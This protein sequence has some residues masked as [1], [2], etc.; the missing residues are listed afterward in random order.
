MKRP[1]LSF[2]GSFSALIAGLLAVLAGGCAPATWESRAQHALRQVAEGGGDALTRVSA[3]ELALLVRG[4]LAR[5]RQLLYS[6]L[7]GADSTAPLRA[8][9]ALALVQWGR[10]TGDPAVV[11]DAVVAGLPG[12]NPVQA[13]ALAASARVVWGNTAAPGGAPQAL[14]D[15]LR[16]VAARP[17]GRWSPARVEAL[18]QLQTLG[19]IAPELDAQ[20]RAFERGGVITTWTLSAP[21]GDSPAF[22]AR[23]RLG[24]EQRPLRSKEQTGVGWSASPRATWALTFSDGELAFPD[25]PRR[26]GVGFAEAWI[27]LPD[28]R[29]DRRVVARL[30]SNRDV[31]L[32]IDATRVIEMDRL[33]RRQ[34][35]Q[36]RAA[37]ELPR[38]PVRVLVKLAGDQPGGFA[39]V[40]ITPWTDG[41]ADAFVRA[42]AG[43]KQSFAG[44]V[45]VIEPPRDYLGAFARP[46][47]VGDSAA[48]IQAL[49]VFDALVARPRRDSDAAYRQLQK[50]AAAVPGFPGLGLAQN[51]LHRVDSALATAQSRGQRRTALEGVLKRWPRNLPSHIAMTQLELAEGRNDEALAS[52]RQALKAG[53]RD[54]SARMLELGFYRK[55]GWEAEAVA[56]ARALEGR[57]AHSPRVLQE[58][59]DTFRSYG[60]AADV[61]RALNALEVAFPQQAVVRR[62]RWHGDRGEFAPRAR[63]LLGHW[64][65]HPQR[66]SLIQRGVR[67]LRSAGKHQEASEAVQRLL[68]LRPADPWALSEAIHLAIDRGD[69]AASRGAL[70]GALKM[71]PD[72]LKLDSLRHWLVG[73]RPPLR[74]VTDSLSL[75]AAYRARTPSADKG[76]ASGGGGG[77]LADYPVVTLLDRTVIDV[78]P[79]GRRRDL[80]HVVRVVQSKSG[81]DKLG[82]LRPPADAQL[83][84]VR[85][86]K[87]DGRVLWPDRV[88]GKPDLSFSGLAPG[89]AVE[90]AWIRY[91]D[92]R[93]EEGGYVTG[94]GFAY[95]SVPTLRKEVD[96]AISPM[97]QLQLHTHNGAPSPK[98]STVTSDSGDPGAARQL[99]RWAVDALPAVPREPLAVSARLFFPYVDLT[100]WPAVSSRTADKRAAA[101]R[102]V[103]KLYAGRLERLTQ[104]GPRATRSA[105]MMRKRAQRGR[106]KSVWAAFDYVKEEINHTERLNTFQLSAEQALAAQKGNRSVAL[107]AVAR[108]LGVATDLVLCAPRPY[109]A[110]VDAAAPL[111][112]ANRFYYPVVRLRQGGEVTYADPSRPYNPFGVLPRS[113]YSARCL[114]L[115]AASEAESTLKTALITLPSY[116][117]YEGTLIGWTFDIAIAVDAKGGGQGVLEGVGF[118]PVAS[119]LRHVYL[120]ADERRRESLWQQWTASVLKGARV[121]DW[122]VDDEIDADKPITWRVEFTIPTFLSQDGASLTKQTLLTNTL[123]HYLGSVAPLEGLARLPSRTTPLALKPHFEEVRLRVRFPKSG[124]AKVTTGLRDHDV[125]TEAFAAH[126]HVTITDSTLPIE[127]DLSVGPGRVAPGKYAAFRKQVLAVVEAFGRGVTYGP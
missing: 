87:R 67:A 79:D 90:W 52:L 86:I 117:L 19:R 57:G 127:R 46:I 10:S 74:D 94:L 7:K 59:L 35:W 17:G 55:R 5:S 100:V 81:A 56:A 125:D 101:W 41:G 39:R 45:T 93:A 30:E 120:N 18:T 38:G 36:K 88:A 73:T 111:P 109:G 2:I 58:V 75:I 49:H 114:D 48:A 122:E 6:V 14:V 44:S 15:A 60:R 20:R 119:G 123:A 23:R 116:D 29:S 34:A 72:L 31:S 112:N 105:A 80:T 71:R 62:A 32:W 26:G 1:C 12:S 110:A 25:M 9:A 3:G 24:P 69:A 54:L 106:M 66:L 28:E 16:S 61:T 97:F 63:L 70:E 99:Y 78:G 95:W 121:V 108:A 92:V 50:V 68:S 8:R 107:V 53:P 113:L 118:G 85:T 47:P 126:Q 4:D 13:E 11:A 40:R 91:S 65:H 64:T 103:A 77:A 33:V 89:D 37:F 115:A 98:V 96:V 43:R 27:E 102:A 84:V 42:S 124:G 22:D 104:V 76:G 21:W 82:E 83:L 51:R